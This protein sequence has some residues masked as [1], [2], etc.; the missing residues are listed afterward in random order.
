MKTTGKNYLQGRGANT[1]PSTKQTGGPVSICL[2]IC[3][4]RLITTA[5][6]LLRPVLNHHSLTLGLRMPGGSGNGL[7]PNWHELGKQEKCSSLAPPRSKFYKTQLAWQGV[8]LTG[9]MSI[10]T[11]KIF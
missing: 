9:L 1:F 6:I 2:S 7:N 10:F 4:D 8:K 3:S 5:N 11:S